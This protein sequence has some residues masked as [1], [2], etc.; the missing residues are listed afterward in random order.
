MNRKEFDNSVGKAYQIWLPAG[1]QV[2]MILRETGDLRPPPEGA[3]ELVRRDPFFLVFDGPAGAQLPLEVLTLTG[4]GGEE[5]LLSLNAE[6]YIDNDPE[7][8][9]RYYVVVN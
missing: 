8:G 9:F 6:G 1:G 3:P 7:K 2:E 4:P 5:Y